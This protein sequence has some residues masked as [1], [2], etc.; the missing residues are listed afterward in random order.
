MGSQIFEAKMGGKQS[1]TALENNVSYA[2]EAG[3]AKSRERHESAER[4]LCK[5]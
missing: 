5:V 1:F 3:F 2:Q 4:N